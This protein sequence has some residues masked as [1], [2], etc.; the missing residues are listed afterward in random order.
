MIFLFAHS[1][2]KL[3]QSREHSDLLEVTIYTGRPHQIRIHLASQGTPLLGDPL[4]KSAG[5]VS[6]QAT[7]GDGG[8]YLHSHKL[9]NVTIEDQILSF[10]AQLPKIL[11]QN[12]S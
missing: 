10:E 1:K 5:K 6:S 7:P 9:L 3:I 12:K 2:I 4:Y 8:Y 11:L